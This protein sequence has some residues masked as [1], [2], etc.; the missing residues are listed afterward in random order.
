MTSYLSKGATATLLSTL[1]PSGSIKFD[2]EKLKEL[3]RLL[4]T[5]QGALEKAQKD[6]AKKNKEIAELQKKQQQNDQVERNAQYKIQQLPSELASTTA[7]AESESTD[8]LKKRVQRDEKDAAAAL[9]SRIDELKKKAA[10]TERSL[11]EKLIRISRD[12]VKRAESLRSLQGLKANLERYIATQTANVETKRGAY[13]LQRSI[14][15][16]Y[17]L[18]SK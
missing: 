2:M 11:R 5:G 15:N 4:K 7:R 1:K 13:Q 10:S 12:K 18:I 8:A 6:K 17:K 9:Q 16:S 3:E 14:G